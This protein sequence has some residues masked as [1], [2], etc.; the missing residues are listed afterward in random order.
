MIGAYRVK[1]TRWDATKPGA[2]VSTSTG[3]PS[4]DHQA[5]DSVKNT[6]NEGLT[7]KRPRPVTE[8]SEYAAFARRILRAYGRRI[9]IGDI[10]S[11]THLIT[12]ADDINDSIQKAVNGLRAA[13]YSWTDIGTQLAITRQ[14][15]Q[16]RWGRQT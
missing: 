3:Q 16:Q 6:V 14:A 2:P 5:P 12:L 13:G 1:P 9:A 7:P 4:P 8:N 11:L 10:E 15:A